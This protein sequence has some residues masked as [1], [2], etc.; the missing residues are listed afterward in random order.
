MSE[1]IT[2][3]TAQHRFEIF[4]DDE[5]AGFAAYRPGEGVREFDH[6]EVGGE[7]GGR[8]LAGKVVAAALSDTEEAG[9]AIIPA[10]SYVHK[11][12]VKHPEH[13]AHVPAATRTAMDL[14]EPA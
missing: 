3:N 5:L 7:F 1:R 11:Y 10:C 14:P 4:V 2:H 13:L 9:L 6:T 12:V 8:G